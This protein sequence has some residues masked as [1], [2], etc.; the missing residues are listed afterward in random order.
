MGDTIPSGI[1]LRD[2]DD[3]EGTV[4]GISQGYIL[5]LRFLEDSI[6]LRIEQ[7]DNT[8]VHYRE[9]VSRDFFDSRQKRS[10]I[11][12]EVARQT[13]LDATYVKDRFRDVKQ[14]IDTAERRAMADD[15]REILERTEDVRAYQTPEQ[16]TI[17]VWVEPPVDSHITETRRFEF[18]APEFQ[19]NSADPV[20]EKHFR[21]F[22][23]RLRIADEDWSI[24]RDEWLDDLELEQSESMSEDDVIADRIADV[25]SS[26]V[27]SRVYDDLEPL[28]NSDTAAFYEPA[29][30]SEY[31]EDTVWIQ[32]VAIQQVIESET[33]KAPAAYIATLSQ[34]LRRQDATLD[35]STRRRV[36]GDRTSM[37]PFRADALGVDELV[38]Q[39]LDSDEDSED[40]ASTGGVIEQ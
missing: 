3:Y 21:V 37:Y 29:S 27:S 32:S 2:T 30:E 13:T 17:A 7:E 38:V 18:S 11:A 26:R 8:E 19:A 6:R 28:A 36:N 12:N 20:K 10:T 39:S 4:L 35:S 23:T 31:D 15:G 9:D 1:E 34:T 5:A 25:L 40:E 24:I 16:L 33:S 22:L 14:F